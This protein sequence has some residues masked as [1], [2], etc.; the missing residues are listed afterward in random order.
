MTAGN[1]FSARRRAFRTAAAAPSAGGF[2]L[3]LDDK[4]AKTRGG[5]P[6][7]VPTQ[8]LGAAI[9]D[10]WRSAGEKIDFAKMPL[11]R[12]AAT[13][14]D[15]AHEAPQWAEETLAFARTDLLSYR[16]VEPAA[17]VALQERAWSPFLAWAADAI[18]ACLVVTSGVIAVAQPDAALAAI[19][20]RLAEFDTWRLLGV[21]RAAELS[22][23]AALALALERRLFPADEIF[24]ASRL[25]ERFQAEKWGVDDEAAARER[26]IEMDFMAAARWLVLL[27]PTSV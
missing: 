23:S 1:A 13:A 17:L 15:R 10:E 26:R 5:A 4:P 25:D 12:L 22:G 9:A 14:I 2:A 24:A 6:L 21:R 20:Q 7:T 18:G 27:D 16:A 3:L 8:T 11:T 19:S